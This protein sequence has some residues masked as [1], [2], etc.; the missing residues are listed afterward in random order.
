MRGCQ[1]RE[2]HTRP[3]FSWK[4]DE[5]VALGFGQGGESFI[6]DLKVLRKYKS[7][8]VTQMWFQLLGWFC[9]PDSPVQPREQTQGHWWDLLTSAIRN[10]SR[11]PKTGCHESPAPQWSASSWLH[12]WWRRTGEDGYVSE[13]IYIKDR[14]GGKKAD[15]RREK[16]KNERERRSNWGSERRRAPDLKTINLTNFR[17]PENC[18]H[19]DHFEFPALSLKALKRKFYKDSFVC[20]IEDQDR[21]DL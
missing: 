19:V 18:F 17:N 6:C 7:Q 14:G 20:F 5:I 10:Q 16:E 1:S 15:W 13:R 2:R 21:N 9:W 3:R 12:W 4:R 11:C 8:Q